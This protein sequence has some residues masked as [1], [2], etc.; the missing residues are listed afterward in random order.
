MQFAMRY[1]AAFFLLSR[2][3]VVSANTEYEVI[4]YSNA[5]ATLSSNVKWVDKDPRALV[6]G[7]MTGDGVSYISAT[8]D[9]ASKQPWL[10]QC[11]SMAA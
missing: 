10:I 7:K 5:T 6:D 11:Y 2:A 4:P 8:C 9:A 3:L 1:S